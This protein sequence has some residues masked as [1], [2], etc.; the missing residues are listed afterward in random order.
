MI[1]R[2]WKGQTTHE[3]SN[4]YEQ[5]LKE[6]VFPRIKA[7]NVEGYK[8]IQLL[9]D[10]K[11]HYVDFITIM[12]FENWMSVKNFAG[13]DYEKSYVIDEAKALLESYDQKAAHYELLHNTMSLNEK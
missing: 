7:K 9:K 10:Q 11:D 8:G 5:L 2:I 4:K 6:V 13:E 12:A 1:I 3:N